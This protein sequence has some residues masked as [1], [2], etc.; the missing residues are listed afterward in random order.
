M[1]GAIWMESELTATVYSSKNR[2]DIK[3]LQVN[4][5]LHALAR[6]NFNAGLFPVAGLG[7]LR[8]DFNK[9]SE[10]LEWCHGE[11]IT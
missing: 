6:G 1:P 11:A 3:L 7:M 5:M 9:W 10:T 8:S 2:S 4:Q